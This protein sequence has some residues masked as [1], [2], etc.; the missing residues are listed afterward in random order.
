ML[1]QLSAWWFERTADIVANHVVAVP[2]PNVLRRPRRRDRCPVEVVVRGYITGV[3]D[4]SLWRQYAD[5]ARTIYGY[6]LPRRAGARTRR[7]PSRIVTPDHEGR[8]RRPR[9]AADVRRGRRR[10]G[11]LDAD[12]WERVIGRPRSELFA[13]GAERRR[14]RPG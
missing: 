4:T 1:N 7:C 5:G 11:S 10:A 12:L 13:R 2:D 14:A 8:A 6:R 9:R 3:T